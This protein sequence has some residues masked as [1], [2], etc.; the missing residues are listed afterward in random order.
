MNV[1][2]HQIEHV[3]RTIQ[4]SVS[5]NPPILALSLHSVK[6]IRDEA[7]QGAA[8]MAQARSLNG[9]IYMI[10]G[11]TPDEQ[12]TL[13]KVTMAFELPRALDPRHLWNRQRVCG[14][15]TDSQAEPV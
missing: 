13:L 6:A 11:T 4:S 9:R 10:E 14:M 12:S 15:L 7:M 5:Y 1:Y 3:L 2:D 8:P